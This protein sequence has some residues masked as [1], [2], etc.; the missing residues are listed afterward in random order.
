MTKKNKA[1][2]FVQLIL[3]LTVLIVIT[4]FA[5]QPGTADDP[6]V[7]KSYVDGRIDELLNAVENG[8]NI[9]VVIPDDTVSG[10]KYVPVH[11]GVSQKLIGGEGTEIIMRTGRAFAFVPGKEGIINATLGKDLLDSAEINKN[12]IIIIPRNDGR[13][14]R[15]VEDAWFIVKGEYT[16]S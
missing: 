10:D 9:P 15:V 4:V 6:I 14:I 2:I 16:I 11:V 12:N 5:A 3:I 13:G 1:F 7:T 8:G